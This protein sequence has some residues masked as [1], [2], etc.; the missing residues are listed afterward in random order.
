[1]SQDT[2]FLMK[3]QQLAGTPA[4]EEVW[5]VSWRAACSV[6]SGPPASA[7]SSAGWLMS[8][9]LPGLAKSIEDDE[10][11]PDACPRWE[12]KLRAEGGHTR[13]HRAG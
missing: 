2:A 11:L 5:E 1:M 6:F 13:A 3:V 10:R 8:Q 9:S 4:E 12:Q 7:V